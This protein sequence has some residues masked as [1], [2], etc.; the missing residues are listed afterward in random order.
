MIVDIDVHHGNGIQT[1][2]YDS[3]EVLYI[4]LHQ[5]PC[6]P[7]T[8]NFGDVGQGRGEGFTVNVPLGKGHGDL[9]YATTVYYLLNPLAQSYHPDMILVSC[10]FDLYMY[11]RL[12]E[13]MSRPKDMD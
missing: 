5:F 10:G 13:M 9:D 12:G 8:G 2:F 11:D 1:A 7:G 3:S 6:Y 4:S